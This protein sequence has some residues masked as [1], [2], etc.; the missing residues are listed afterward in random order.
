LKK[1]KLLLL[2]DYFS[3][4]CWTIYYKWFILLHYLSSYYLCI[5][6]ITTFCWTIYYKWFMLL[7]FLSSYYLFIVVVTTF[8]WTI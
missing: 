5:V 3:V 4:V 7:H 6:V 8:C 1:E 2:C